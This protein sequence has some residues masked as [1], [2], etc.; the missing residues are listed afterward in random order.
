M[1]IRHLHESGKGCSAAASVG[2]SWA[3]LTM[4]SATLLRQSSPAVQQS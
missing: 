4:H 2:L 1:V 3:I